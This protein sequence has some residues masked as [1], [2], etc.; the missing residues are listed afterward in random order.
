MEKKIFRDN[1][2]GLQQFDR[3]VQF[4]NNS[5]HFPLLK[6]SQKK[7]IT[8]THFC[9]KH[10]DQG[11]EGACAGF[12][13][14]HALLTPTFRAY[15][16]DAKYAKERVYWNAQR[17]DPWHGGSYPDAEPRYE[18][19]SVLA[20]VKVLKEFG[21]ID[22]YRW[23]FSLRDLILGI[24][25]EGPAVLG[26]KWL[27]GMHSPDGEGFIHV[28]GKI[29]GGHCI[30]CKGV[31]IE[32][33]YFILHNS[34][35]STWGV[36]GDCYISFSDMEKLLALQGEIVFLQ[37]TERLNLDPVDSLHY[38]EDTGPGPIAKRFE[39]LIE[40]PINW[41]Y[42]LRLWWSQRRHR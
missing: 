42:K 3:L 2:Y 37:R 29:N 33:R 7:A 22:S 24:G 38:R 40:V 19:T 35:G 31:N 32:E 39:W 21:W 9:G 16:L 12:G 20:G 17:I 18:G 4:D 34:W 1:T 27:E 36:K 5:K 30:L 10:L 8:R 23:G 11:L 26:V 13:L 28:T 15:G 6:L 25:H 41:G 14:T